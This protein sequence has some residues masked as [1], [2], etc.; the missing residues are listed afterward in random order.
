ML[1]PCTKELKTNNVRLMKPCNESRSRNK[2]C[3]E[4]EATI[5]KLRRGDDGGSHG[6]ERTVTR[7]CRFKRRH[8]EQHQLRRAQAASCGGECIRDCAKRGHESRGGAT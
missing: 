8:M 1:S 5:Q 2:P 6:T 3:R 4:E 7:R